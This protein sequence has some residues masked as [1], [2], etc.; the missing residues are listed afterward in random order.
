MA[1]DFSATADGL[2]LVD[3]AQTF[4][5][6]RQAALREGGD[7]A[8]SSATTARVAVGDTFT[9][10]IFSGDR[11]WVAVGLVAGENYVFTA[12]GT[13]GAAGVR[14]TLLTLR[15]GS[16][17]V[18][19]SHDDVVP[20]K[21]LSSVVTFTPSVSG[22]YYL[23]VG[24]FG[25][26]QYTLRT[27]T[28]VFTIEQVA[29]QLT[30]MGWG[31]A[32]SALRFGINASSTL[33]INLTGLTAQGAELARMALETWTAY[34]GI[35]FRE[36][37]SG[38]A[39][40]GFDDFAARFGSG[41]LYAFAGPLT[42]DQ[43]TGVY[44]SAS[45]TVSTAWLQQ[46][47]TTYGSYSYLTYLHEIGHAL[48]LGHGGF[49][50][51]SAQ[52]GI[53]NHY[54]NDSYQLTIMS[55]FDMIQNTAINATDFLP[56]TPMAGDIAAIQ[57]LYGTS[58]NVFAGNT[59]WG[60][61]SNISGSLG[62][63]M[64]VLFDGDARPSWMVTNE[65][66]GI[67]IMDSS[68]IDTM[69]FSGASVAQ[70]IDMR[71]RGISDVYGRTGTVVVALGTVIENAVGG[72]GRD[73]ING[74]DAA[75]MVLGRGGN[76]FIEGL[77]GNDTILGGL[78]D[79]IVYANS[80][81][82]SVNGE[83]GNDELWGGP[84]NDTV[85]GGGGSDTMGGAAGNDFLD[86]GA[87]RDSLWGGG[88]RDLLYGGADGDE[89]AGGAASDTIYGGDG[90]D[91]VFAAVAD[92]QI[93]G[94]AGDDFIWAGTGNDLAYGGT[95]NDTIAAGT[96]NDTLYGNAGAD[97]FLFYGNN[98]QDTIMDFNGADGDRLQ[99]S[100]SAWVSVHGNLTAEQV[101]NSFGSLD[102]NGNVVLT[103]GTSGTSIVLV[104]VTNLESID[105]FISII[106]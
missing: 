2:G 21:H 61:N 72:N 16:G 37:T 15:G 73:T 67:T 66:F 71:A 32:A 99:L 85:L 102:A 104:G 83:D 40:I 20:F 82:D 45:V 60:A 3:E 79:D 87:G 13:G 53:D 25:T 26:G 92:D 41:A 74:N 50:D 78:G 55:Y 57:Y 4:A 12:Y 103:L 63:A 77:G 24:T 54:I 94:E 23:D 9:G 75:N 97:V 44:T 96:G 81:N 8:G 100:Q 39:S 91:T 7:A 5:I 51:G 17:Q 80:G 47:G 18:I 105:Q 1:R 89:L 101:E 52:Y 14:D 19:A 42:V 98:G 30:D 10:T 90:N 27:S 62:I 86:G 59:V 56:I 35:T 84:G 43:Q 36:V 22:T 95:G 64:G 6:T 49:Y 33:T 88:G 38:T 48:G 93:F 58:A 106:A 68:G 31:F 28:N 29:S 65:T 76:D 34:T 70:L 46:F 11:D 69:D